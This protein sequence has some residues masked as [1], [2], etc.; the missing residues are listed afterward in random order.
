MLL[1]RN[2]GSA[3]KGSVSDSE[4]SSVSKPQGFLLKKPIEERRFGPEVRA[5][6]ARQPLSSG[7]A[8]L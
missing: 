7:A 4:N 1:R 3:I 6:P 8:M 2:A 5:Q